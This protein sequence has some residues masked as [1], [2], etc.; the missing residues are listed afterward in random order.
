M[1]EQVDLFVDG[2]RVNVMPFGC[3]LVFTLSHPQPESQGLVAPLPGT[4]TPVLPS[5]R[6]ATIRMTPAL[7]KGMAFILRNQLARFEQTSHTT[8]EL[9]QDAMPSVLAGTDQAAWERFWEYP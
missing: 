6:V 2:F 3:T 4:T 7:M 8:I 5:D 9:P 1:A